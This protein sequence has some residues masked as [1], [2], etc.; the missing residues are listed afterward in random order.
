VL[1][2]IP[3]FLAAPADAASR[4]ACTR[5]RV[6]RTFTGSD[7]RVQR[8]VRVVENGRAVYR[9]QTTISAPAATRPRATTAPSGAA[10]LEG[11][12]THDS[13]LYWERILQAK[14]L[15]AAADTF[16]VTAG[17]KT[18]VFAGTKVGVTG[19]FEINVQASDG[20]II[21]GIGDH[22]ASASLNIGPS[23]M[24]IAGVG[25]DKLEVTLVAQGT[26]LPTQRLDSVTLR[27]GQIIPYSC[28]G[29]V[30]K[31]TEVGAGGSRV[32]TQYQRVARA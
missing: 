18:L 10:C 13:P 15:G 32:E 22:E 17:V 29:D 9:W 6:G 1:G 5:A 8:C 3:A 23:T 16:A 27:K 26:T 11:T 24:Q 14:T 7:A 20:A 25:A 21:T 30:L 19:R 2:P 4:P 28:E 31:M 12:W